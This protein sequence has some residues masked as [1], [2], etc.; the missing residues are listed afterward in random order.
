MI[1]S[2]DRYGVGVL[3]AGAQRH[4]TKPPGMERQAEPEPR[5]ARRESS[6]SLSFRPAASL[7]A[8]ARAAKA[9]ADEAMP[10][11]D[12]KLFSLTTS[13]RASRPRRPRTRSR[14]TA[15]R[16]Q[17]GTG[18]L[19]PIDDQFVKGQGRLKADRGARVQAIEVHR[20]RAVGRQA[21]GIIPIAP[22]LD[23]GDVRM[24][25]RGGAVH[26]ASLS[27]GAAHAPLKTPVAQDCRA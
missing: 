16:C 2:G 15:T 4:S 12:G 27:R 25:L 9:D 6:G 26:A 14:M 19:M 21:Q 17:G 18:H 1:R 3:V 24:G 5:R 20:N 13:A 23:E 11:P 10:A 8:R 22:V 7:A